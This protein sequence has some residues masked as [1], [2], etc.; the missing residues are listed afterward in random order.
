MFTSREPIDAVSSNRIFG[1]GSISSLS[2]GDIQ[3][4]TVVGGA[5]TGVTLAIGTQFYVDGAGNVVAEKYYNKWRAF[6]T[7][8][9]FF[10]NPRRITYRFKCRYYRNN[11]CHKEELLEGLLLHLQ[12]LLEVEA[13][14]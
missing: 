6:K 7:R 4:N 2:V 1:V 5:I 9:L 8:F 11:Y 10:S 14:I 12:L 13:L 3:A